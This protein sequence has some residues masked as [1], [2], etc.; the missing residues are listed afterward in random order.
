VRGVGQRMFLVDEE[1]LPLLSL[2]NLRFGT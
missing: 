1:A 2:Q